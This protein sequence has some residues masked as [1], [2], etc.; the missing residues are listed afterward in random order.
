[1]Q[2]PKPIVYTHAHPLLVSW[3]SGHPRVGQGS[4]DGSIRGL[5]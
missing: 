1:M 2:I 3:V 4:G 5:S